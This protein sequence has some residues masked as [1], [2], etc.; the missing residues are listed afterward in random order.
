[1]IIL[2]AGLVLAIIASIGSILPIVKPVWLASVTVEDM[3][4]VGSITC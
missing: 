3:N 1:M 2:T 4:P